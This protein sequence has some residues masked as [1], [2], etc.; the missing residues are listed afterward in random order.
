MTEQTES[1]LA[2]VERKQ[3]RML[4]LLET[5]TEKVGEHMESAKEAH[6]KFARVLF[7]D[8]N[9]RPGHNVRLDRL[10]QGAERQKWFLRTVGGALALMVLKMLV[11][12]L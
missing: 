4:L 1:R 3:D 2:E 7:G 9:G 5:L 11:E 12:I 10:E 6:E 8:G